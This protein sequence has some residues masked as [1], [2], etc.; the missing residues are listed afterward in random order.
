M[1]D[2]PPY[3]TFG[4]A[5][6]LLAAKRRAEERDRIIVDVAARGVWEIEQYLR[7]IAR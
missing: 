2:R 5:V 6:R 3:I 4:Q 1:P 7:E